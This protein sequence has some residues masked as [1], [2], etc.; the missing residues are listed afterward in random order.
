MNFIR[1]CFKFY[2]WRR[3]CFELVLKWLI[4]L[5]IVNLRCSIHWSACSMLNSWNGAGRLAK[6]DMQ[7][8][9]GANSVVSFRM[10]AR[11]IPPLHSLSPTSADWWIKRLSCGTGI[12]GTSSKTSSISVAMWRATL[13]TASL[14]SWEVWMTWK[15]SMMA[16]RNLLFCKRKLSPDHLL[17]Y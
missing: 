4:Y 6:Y 5:W 11:C 8:Y 10:F 9:S 1:N 15:S 12:A 16:S 3:R 7:K 17:Q 14:G 13:V 2:I